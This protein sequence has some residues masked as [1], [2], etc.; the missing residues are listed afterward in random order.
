MLTSLN[1]CSIA[2]VADWRACF[3]EAMETRPT[4]CSQS[5]SLDTSCCSANYSGTQL[6]LNHTGRLG[7]YGSGVL[8]TPCVPTRPC[9]GACLAP[10]LP[11]TLRIWDL[12]F[13]E[14]ADAVLY[15]GE[16]EEIWYSLDVQ[17]WHSHTGWL[18]A[19]PRLLETL[20]QYT[21][22]LSAALGLL[23]AAPIYHLDGHHL[24]AAVFGLARLP[25]PAEARLASALLFAGSLLFGCN[26]VVSFNS[27]L[28]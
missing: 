16:P 3:L 11:P 4:Y 6:C 7:C 21:A 1:E 26:L 23:N 10:V 5:P 18:P 8:R 12:R 13:T 25:P 27:L 28:N 22:S 20:L 17:D 19:L 24:T 2:S 15:L 14:P 9:P